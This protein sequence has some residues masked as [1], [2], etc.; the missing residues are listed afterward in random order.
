MKISEAFAVPTVKK[1]TALFCRYLDLRARLH[2]KKI[3]SEAFLGGKNILL[4][5][6]SRVQTVAA[7]QIGLMSFTSD[8]KHITE[9]KE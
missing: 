9:P 3:G 8:K 5:Q 7:G 1:K 6:R 4:Q 2:M